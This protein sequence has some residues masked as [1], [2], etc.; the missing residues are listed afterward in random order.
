VFVLSSLSE[1]TSISLLEALSTS[2][3]PVVTRVGGNAHVLG[4]D[5]AHR[6][7]E[8]GN[9]ESIAEGLAR[10]CLDAPARRDD[11]RRGRQRVQDTFDV[12]SMVAA[13]TRLYEAG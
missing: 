9:P 5:L 2:C 11:A 3:C 7:V 4:P 12:R 6:L 8:S 10:A 13:Y 1:G